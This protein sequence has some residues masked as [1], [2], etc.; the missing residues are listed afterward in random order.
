VGRFAP[1]N[2]KAVRAWCSSQVVGGGPIRV[3]DAH[4]VVAVVRQLAISKQYRDSAVLATMKVL[5]A[6]G[7]PLP[8]T[9]GGAS[10]QR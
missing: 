8:Q 7:N 5:A 10:A 3:V 9:G 1:R 4:E 2:E 6:T